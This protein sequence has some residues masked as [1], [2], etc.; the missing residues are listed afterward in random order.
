MM[1]CIPIKKKTIGAV[2]SDFKRAQTAG[3]LTEIWFDELGSSLTTENLQ[4][5]FKIK[6]KPIIYKSFG[7]IEKLKLVL[8]NEIEYL[9]LDLN[10]SAKLI[11]EVKKISPQT[12]I[13]FSVHDFEKMPKPA[14]LS[15][16]VKKMLAKKA[17]ICKIATTAKTFEDSLRML[18]F[19]ST[20]K[21]KN[22]P[23]ICLCMG[24][25]GLLTRTAGHLFGNYLMYAPL[26][27]KDKTAN[28][29]ITA[30]QLKAIICH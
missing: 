10:S 27:L 29:Q 16:I 30:K 21:A 24:P 14:V 5:I 13:I 20:L 19:L 25:K 17:D 3:D 4:R 1:I 12:K 6:R 7:E 26:D 11:S 22:I 8:K 15:Q 9:D 2:L 23:A 18:S 28:G